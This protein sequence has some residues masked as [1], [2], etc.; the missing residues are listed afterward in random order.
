MKFIRFLKAFTLRTEQDMSDYA[1]LKERVTT[2]IGVTRLLTTVV[3]A[4]QKEISD[5]KA[6]PSAVPAQD[7]AEI[8]DPIDLAI[9]EGQAVIPATPSTLAI[10]GLSHPALA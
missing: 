9:A 1:T 8:T 7:Y 4:Q 10:D 5:L 2:L 3:A 6:A